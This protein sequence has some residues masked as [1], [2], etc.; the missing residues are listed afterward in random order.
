MNEE[1]KKKNGRPKKKI[2]KELVEKLATIHCSVKEI[3]DIVGCHPDTIRNRF[4]DTISRGK[5]NGKMSVRRKMLETAM[6]GNATLL[7]WLSKNWLGMS[8]NP[9]DD[10]TQKILPWTDDIDAAE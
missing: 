6:T 10:D 3:A 8:D 7:I 2:D 9:L 5:A 4:A 1:E